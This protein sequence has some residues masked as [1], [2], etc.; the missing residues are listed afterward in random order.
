MAKILVIDDEEIIRKTMKKLLELDDYEIF[1][2]EN[3]PKGLDIFRAE[4]PEVAVV[5]IKMPG[6]D[7]IEVL[8]TIRAESETTQ[9]ILVTGHGGVDTA[10]QALRE[11][12]FGYLQKP[13]EYDELEIEI[14]KALEK[15]EM[16]RKLDHNVNRLETTNQELEKVLLH[17]RRDYEIAEKV[18]DKIVKADIHS[19]CPNV[20]HFLSPMNTVAGDLILFS[21]GP[22]GSQYIFLGDF[23]GHG[24]SAAI[25]AVPVSSVFYA[26]AQKGYAISDI[27]LEINRKLKDA[28]PTGL[29]LCA[30]L[31]ELNYAQG[32][33]HLWNG[34]LPD[35]LIADASNGIKNR[36]PSAHLPLGVVG[37]S[38]VDSKVEFAKLTRGDRIYVYSDGIIEAVNKDGEMFGEERFEQNILNADLFDNSFE[39]IRSSLA[40]FR[41]DM[42]QNDD[43]TLMEVRYDMESLCDLHW[44]IGSKGNKITSGWK[45]ALEMGPNDLRNEAIMPYLVETLVGAERRVLDHRENI[46]LI[47]AELFVNALD[48]GILGL[49]PAKKK[50]PM[51]FVEYHNSREKKLADLK[52]GWVKIRLELLNQ[53]GNENLVVRVEDSGPGYDYNKTL[54]ALSENIGMGGRGVPL[55]RTICRELTYYGKGNIVEAIYDIS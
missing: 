35:V 4:G 2:A 6:M 15:N 22:T 10:I 52:S 1:T 16:Q 28:L 39:E 23:T 24:L 37:N 33:V 46:Y 53:N 55:V 3:G 7:G 40:A 31:F 20:K 12:A 14:R 8:K 27:V 26:M 17:L 9:V 42:P 50:D 13:V 11:G 49:D 36:F 29:F 18:F 19:G 43:M 5:D 44:K 32:T 38:R 48:Y 30:C 41:G 25:G 45:M 34:G 21:V 54:P 47:L 51:G